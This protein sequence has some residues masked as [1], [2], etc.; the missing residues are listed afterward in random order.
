[1]KYTVT[2]KNRE[3]LVLDFMRLPMIIIVLYMHIIPLDP[4][5]VSFDL[6]WDNV[7]KW[8]SSMIS[9]NF[10][11]AVVPSF[12]MLSGYFYF[13]KMKQWDTSFYFKQQK[14]RMRTLV[15][16]YIIFNTLN[17]LVVFIKGFVF[18][19]LGVGDAGMA[20]MEFL[21]NHTFVD[22]YWY[23]PI[24]LPLWFLRDLII[25]T[26]LSPVF[27]YL[28][29]YTKILGLLLL[30]IPYYSGI[31]FPIG[32]S[33]TAIL[34]FGVGVY[35]GLYKISIL[36]I[37]L[38]YKKLILPISVI[39][40]FVSTYFSASPKYAGITES[41]YVPFG[42]L[43]FVV[44]S[45]KFI[46]NDRI[47]NLVLSLTSSV[48][49]IYSIHEI[50]LKNWI[51]GAFYRTSLPDIGGI[52]M[53]VGYIVMPAVLFMICLFL[54]KMMQRFMPKTLNIMCGSR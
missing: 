39:S 15:F 17:I 53:I 13:L 42:I 10:G 52:G 47:R 51:K 9:H 45:N 20:D 8:L 16:P 48:F 30:F 46:D 35:L 2:D 18:N 19:K 23:M 44:V 11:R 25:M 38:K 7:Y 14:N 33:T 43:A 3:S 29:R 22:F 54:Y 12:F 49:F 31:N 32:L 34:F 37:A 6:S 1:M 27:F 36:D 4:I 28:F 26:F 21:K 24:D 40:V 41:I 50:Y 5:S